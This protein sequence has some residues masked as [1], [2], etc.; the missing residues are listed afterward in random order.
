[1][2]LMLD[3]KSIM[4]NLATGLNVRVGGDQKCERCLGTAR[5]AKKISVSEMARRLNISPSFYYKIEQ[6]IRNSTI[7]L[8]KAI[9]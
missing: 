7:D 4:L 2:P 8:A 6:G 1:M 9:G 3:V 5:I